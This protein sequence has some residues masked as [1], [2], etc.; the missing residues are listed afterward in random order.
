MVERV[1]RDLE[2]LDLLDAHKGVS[3]EGDVWRIVREGTDVLQGY[4][5]KARWDPGTFDVLYTSLEREGALEE[6][7]FHLSRQPVFPSKLRSSLHRIAVRTQRTLKL[8]DLE[9][10]RGLGVAA[11]TY[12]SLAY[13]RTQQIGDAAAFLGFDGI[14]APS[15]RHRCQNLIIFCDKFSPA[16]VTVVHSEL[17]DWTAWRQQRKGP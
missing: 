16:D 4:P 11:E 17:V 9:G 7:Y 2:L 15:A 8:A 12:S 3:F 6:I 13:E 14:L 10:V 5:A 1:A